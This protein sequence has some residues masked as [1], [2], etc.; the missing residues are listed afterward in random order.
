MR[1]LV[2]WRLGC[3]DG[4]VVWLC[5]GEVVLCRWSPNIF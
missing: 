1:V 5:S 2:E 4:V 3:V